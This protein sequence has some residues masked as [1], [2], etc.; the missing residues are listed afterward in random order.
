MSVTDHTDALTQS[1]LRS[2]EEGS[3]AS[4]L[5]ES[6][7]SMYGG[8]AQD[9]DLLLSPNSESMNPPPE[10]AD[11][12]KYINIVDTLSNDQ[13]YRLLTQPFMPSNHY[14]FPQCNKYGKNCSFQIGWRNIMG[15]STLPV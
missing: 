7:I 6:D 4:E 14:K 12:G 3:Q 11:F 5:S 10:N 15:W 8:G 2:M 13:K 1:E 9:D